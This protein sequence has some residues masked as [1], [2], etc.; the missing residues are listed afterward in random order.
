MGLQVV[1]SVNTQSMLIIPSYLPLV[2]H[3]GVNRQSKLVDLKQTA[4]SA[5]V[6]SARGAAIT[7]TW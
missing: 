6:V 4:S 7:L 5:Y 3:H 2:R 1:R